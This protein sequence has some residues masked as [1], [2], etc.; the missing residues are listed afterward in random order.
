[1]HHGRAPWRA[2]RGLRTPETNG[3]C[4]WLALQRGL[5]EHPPAILNEGGLIAPGWNARLDE[6]RSLRENGAAAI[7]RFQTDEIGRTGI[8]SLKVGFNRIFGYTIEVSNAH[9]AKVPAD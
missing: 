2:D 7:A 5:A 8:A 9:A 1:M 3:P 4:W 6:L